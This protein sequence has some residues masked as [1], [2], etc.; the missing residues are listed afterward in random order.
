MKLIVIMILPVMLTGC[1]FQTV[2]QYDIVAA[3]KACGGIEKVAEISVWGLGREV[4]TCTDNKK[5]FLHKPV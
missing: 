5:T 1:F 3:I 2:N 4:V